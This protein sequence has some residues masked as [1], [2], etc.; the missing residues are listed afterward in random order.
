MLERVGD[1]FHQNMNKVTVM[2]TVACTFV[3]WLFF[4]FFKVIS[5][6]ELVHLF[7]FVSLV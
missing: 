4:F 5:C 6:I 3:V 7:I 1:Y 2:R